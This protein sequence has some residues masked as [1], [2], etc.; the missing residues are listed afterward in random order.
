[1]G[2]PL[3]ERDLAALEFQ[4]GD[5]ARI[6]TAAG[7]EVRGGTD[8]GANR[9][10][11]VTTDG[12]ELLVFHP[13]DDLLLDLLSLAG[14]ALLAGGLHQAKELKSLPNVAHQQSSYY[15]ELIAFEVS[16]MSVNDEY[17]LPRPGMPQDQRLFGYDPIFLHLAA[18]DAL[19]VVIAQ[20]E[21][22][23]TLPVKLVE[24]VEDTLMSPP[25]FGELPVLPQFV[26]VADL[27]IR[28]TLLIIVVQRV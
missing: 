17:L 18:S 14:A 15:I 11:R 24:Q 22:Q 25:H 16:L 10:M 8:P 6:D 3:D 13:L 23:P 1:V 12:D 28:K 26:S 7:V 19:D 9:V 20:D 2:H 5:I 21:V 4:A 27:D